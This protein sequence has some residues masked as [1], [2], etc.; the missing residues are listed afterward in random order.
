MSPE[1]LGRVKRYQADLHDSDRATA[2]TVAHM[3]EQ[4]HK[5][6][7]DLIVQRSAVDAVRQWRGGPL[8]GMSGRDPFAD[9]LAMAES[10]WWYTKHHVRFVHHN[11]LIAVWFNERD[12]LQLLISPEVL[13]RMD[14]MQGDCAIYTMLICAL[15]EALGL[16]WEIVTAAVDG[17][18]PEVF[19]HVWPRV[20]LPDGW[21]VDLDASHGD[22]VGWHV[23]NERIYK[24]QV[25]NE[26]AR[27]VRDVPAFRGLHGYVRRGMGDDTTDFSPSIP[28]SW[29]TDA[30][31]QPT[32]LDVYLGQQP[33]ATPAPSSSFNWQSLVGNLANQWTQIGS[34]VL[35]PSTTY[36]RNA[37]G[38]VSLVTPGS[39]PVL[40][41][42]VLAGGS[43]LSGST[44]LW[45]GGGL[46]ALFV[47]GSMM[48]KK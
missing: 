5:A 47:V 44:L 9:P 46:A 41:S 43:S 45:I 22:Y 35:A 14:Q 48:G 24:V 18:Q 21:R 36:V 11:E 33:A 17:R 42:S 6:A 8:F 1:F 39:S 30:S 25:W 38:S 2:Q 4:V 34:R 31:S 16:A 12:Q 26:A 3:V 20:V 15:L 7:A 40:S 27:P 19:S 10:C 13:V 29:A 37:D 28:D 32:N 23:P